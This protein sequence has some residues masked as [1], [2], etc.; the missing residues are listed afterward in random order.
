[1]KTF[2]LVIL[3]SVSLM[4]TLTGCADQQ[5]YAAHTP[6]EWTPPYNPGN[7]TQY[8]RGYASVEREEWRECLKFGVAA[9]DDKK[10]PIYEI[11]IAVIES[12]HKEQ[13]KAVLKAIETLNSPWEK[14]QFY[15]EQM[16]YEKHVPP[17]S[18]LVLQNRQPKPEI[19]STNFRSRKTL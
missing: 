10:S 3:T 6:Y 18:K 2:A 17:V 8:Q 12:C 4:L 19:P 15:A 11:A 1:M 16:T 5:R 14:D 13:K 7:A 9:L